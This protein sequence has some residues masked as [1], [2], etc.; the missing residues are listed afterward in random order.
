MAGVP[1]LIIDEKRSGGK[2]AIMPHNCMFVDRTLQD[3]VEVDLRGIKASSL[4]F[5]H[6][7][8]RRPGWNYL[9]RKELA[10]LYFMLFEE[11]TYSRCELKYATNIGNWDGL[12]TN[13]GYNP[14]G[15][16]MAQG[17]LVWRGETLSGMP[18]FLYMREWINPRPDLKIEKMIFRATYDPVPMNP[19]LLA[20]TAVNSRLEEG[21]KE[22]V[23]L[24]SA[25]KLIPPSPS[26]WSFTLQAG[27]TSRNSNT[28]PPM[29]PSSRWPGLRIG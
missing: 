20:I 7:L 19:I 17:K 28:L 18:A 1:F 3:S 15:H 8:D 13:C 16:S 29:A 2:G 25:N 14:K 4:I 5:L 21:G 6:C 23:A 10:G 11:G 9:R 22:L 24:P 27:G 12:P 26:E